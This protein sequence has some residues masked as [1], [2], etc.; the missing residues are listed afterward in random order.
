MNKEITKLEAIIIVFLSFII[1]FSLGRI[2]G[3]YIYYKSIE[4][5]KAVIS[6][7]TK[8]NY[9]FYK[10]NNGYS[11]WEMGCNYTLWSN[12]GWNE[13]TQEYSDQEF[14]TCA[15]GILYQKIK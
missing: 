12:P 5:Q 8:K 9:S 15:N 6:T 3:I 13:K 4:E 11:G 10:G 2:T 14:L 1:G 7:E